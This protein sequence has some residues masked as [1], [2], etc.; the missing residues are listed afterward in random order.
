MYK[1]R[2]NVKG[3]LHGG[4]ATPRD[5]HA[6][7]GVGGEGSASSNGGVLGGSNMTMSKDD[8]ERMMNVPKDYGLLLRLDSTSGNV[9]IHGEPDHYEPSIHPNCYVPKSCNEIKPLMGGGSGTA[10]F[11]GMHPT[12]GSIVMK[13]GGAK[14]TSEVSSLAEIAHEL[15]MRSSSSSSSNCTSRGDEEDEDKDAAAAAAAAASFLKERIPEFVGCYI[16]PH[17]VRDRR[18]EIWTTLREH[19]HQSMDNLLRTL[20]SSSA[21]S[22]ATAAALVAQ[23][24][25]DSSDDDDK[26][27]DEESRAVE[28]YNSKHSDDGLMDKFRRVVVRVMKEKRAKRHIRVCCGDE[29]Q[30]GFEVEFSRVVIYLPQSSRQDDSSDDIVIMSGDGGGYDFLKDFMDALVVEQDL[31]SWKVTLAQKTIGGPQSE[32]GAHVLV[33]KK[34]SGE[35]LTKAISEF[36]AVIQN[37]RL[38]TR[39]DERQAIDAVR[40]EV[41]LLV[42][43][44]DVTLVSK[45]CDEFVGT[46]IRKNFLPNSGRLHKLREIGEQFRVGD[47]FSLTD[48]E[49]FPA[50]CLGR[51][52]VEG[53]VISDVFQDHS[54]SAMS[55]L[56]RMQ[57]TWLDL[58]QTAVSFG[59]PTATNRIWTCGLTDAGLHNTFLSEDRGVEL[60]DLGEPQ[61]MPEPAFLTKFLMSFFHGLGMEDDTSLPN[62]GWVC[63]FDVV[64]NKLSLTKATRDLLPYVYDSFSQTMSH[65]VK[66]LFDCDDRVGILLIRYAVLQLVSDAQFCLGRWEQKGGGRERYGDR[67]VV[68][69]DKWLW[70]SLWDLFIAADVYEKLLHVPV[71]PTQQVE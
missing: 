15:A 17:H 21:S 44:P 71:A 53:V 59:N 70:R 43:N 6:E 30:V 68:P 10:V 54:P 33:S 22:A 51:L 14:E 61:L 62:G 16:S 50:D 26:D 13:H 27:A 48:S 63:R 20:R 67:A 31:H 11:H 34:L 41:E 49:A 1:R 46:A 35:L 65:F 69:L 29:Q 18:H 55:A 47:Q 4:V 52:L 37:L 66:E 40:Q 45:A 24:F 19:K 8:G 56:D 3:I 58:L 36:T 60:F 23:D 57:D 25:D 9:Y 28:E 42:A 39:D 32:N 5:Q 64:G 12:L 38:L 2:V 7:Q